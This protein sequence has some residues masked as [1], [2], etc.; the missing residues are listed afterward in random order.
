MPRL[1]GLG[2]LTLAVGAGLLAAPPLAWA[3]DGTAAASAPV[4]SAAEKAVPADSAAAHALPP[5]TPTRVS[6]RLPDSPPSAL[7]KIYPTCTR[8]V[9]DSCRN[10]GG[11][12]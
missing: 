5:G 10:P 12:R 9:Q 2:A 6:N 11:G 7:N 1:F 4:L 3:Q 8:T